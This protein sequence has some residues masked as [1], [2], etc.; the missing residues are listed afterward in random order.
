VPSC[1]QSGRAQC[2]SMHYLARSKRLTDPVP[3]GLHR[4]RSGED[5]RDELSPRPGGRGILAAGRADQSPNRFAAA[6]AT[7][8]ASLT[9]YHGTCLPLPEELAATSAI[10]I[11][12]SL[13]Q[14]C[15]ALIEVKVVNTGMCVRHSRH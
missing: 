7:L 5:R 13:S 4:I 15:R 3:K 9:R 1:I 8:T 14:R 6:P 2:E 10:L 11:D 12:S